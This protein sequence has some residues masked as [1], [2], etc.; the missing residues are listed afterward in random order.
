MDESFERVLCTPE[1]AGRLRMP[2]YWAGYDMDVCRF[3]RRAIPDAAARGRADAVIVNALMAGLDVSAMAHEIASRPLPAMPA[4][5]AI[6]PAGCDEALSAA[7]RAGV[8]CLESLWA[9]DE[10]IVRTVR[11]LT[12]ENRLP[13]AWASRESV[14]RRLRLLG[15]AGETAGGRYLTRAIMLCARDYRCFGRLST[16]VYPM[17]AREY[18]ARDAAVERLMRHAI[19]S[20]WLHGDIETQYTFFGNTVDASKGKPTNSEFIARITE[21][22]RLEANT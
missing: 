21:A 20:A 15:V 19:E 2:L 1:L 6:F 18:G 16:Q 13:P 5:L 14:E 8:V 7:E 4:L 17:I 22:L 3:D 11:A 9:T 12:L 10:A